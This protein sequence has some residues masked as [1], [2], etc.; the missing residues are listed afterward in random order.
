MGAVPN[1]EPLICNA[2][3][4]KEVRNRY[5]QT[6]K[7]KIIKAWPPESSEWCLPVGFRIWVLGLGLGFGVTSLGFGA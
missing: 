2:T 3:R 7:F 4:E 6:I 1:P 5:Q